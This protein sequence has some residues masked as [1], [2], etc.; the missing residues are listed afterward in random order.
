[1]FQCSANKK[2]PPKWGMVYTHSDY[3]MVLVSRG[4][5]TVS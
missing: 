3:Q 5:L 1:L 4:L 2:A